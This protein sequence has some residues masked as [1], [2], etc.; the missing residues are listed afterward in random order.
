MALNIKKINKKINTSQIT[1][2]CQIYSL[3][4]GEG[5]RIS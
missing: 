3:E 1:S 5:Q 2:R 4:K